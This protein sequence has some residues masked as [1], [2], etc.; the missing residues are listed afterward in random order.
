MK[1]IL[2]LLL[3]GIP[4]L[5]LAQPEQNCIDAIPVCQ[6]TYTQNTSY[7]GGGSITDIAPG[8]TCLGTGETNSVWYIF[9]VQN[10]GTFGFTLNTANDYDYAM[11]DI[12]GQ[13]C[14]IVG[15]TPPLRCNYSATYGLTGLDD[16][17]PQAGNISYNASQQPIMPGLNVVTG[18]TYVLLVNNFSGDTNG[19]DLNFDGTASIFDVTPPAYTIDIPCTDSENIVITINEQID[20]ATLSN[21]S[22]SLSGGGS[23]NSVVGTTC[24]GYSAEIILDWTAAAGGNYTLTS[25]GVADICGNVLTLTENISLPNP[26]TISTVPNPAELCDGAGGSVTLTASEAGGTWSPGGASTTAI[27]VSPSTTTTYTYS[28]GTGCV[29]TAMETVTVHPAPFASITPQNPIICGAGT[30]ALTAVAPPGSSFLW[31]GPDITPANEGNP[32]VLVGTGTYTVTITDVNGCQATDMT[33]VVTN[34]PPADPVCVNVYVSPAGGGTGDSPNSPTDIVSAISASLCSNTV[35]KMQVG[36]YNISAPLTISSNLTLEGGFLADW[37]KTSTDGTLATTTL[38]NRNIAGVYPWDGLTG[39]NEAPA[40]V[41]LTANGAT[42]FRLQDLTIQT[43]NAPASNSINPTGVSTYGVR[44][45]GCSNYNIV[46]CNIQAGNASAGQ[47]GAS[48]TDGADGGNGGPGGVGGS[49][50]VVLGFG[51]G[52]G[53]GGAT[54]GG[55]GFSPVGNTGGGGGNGG[56]AANS[57]SSG[58]NGGSGGGGIGP[59]GN[60]G[61]AGVGFSEFVGFG[62]DNP[63]APEEGGDGSPG[64]PGSPGAVGA[65]GA[66]SFTSGFFVPGTGTNG[67]D[68]THGGG[69][70]GGGGSG[71]QN[72]NF[73]C[74][75]D[76]GSG[77]GGGGGG[78]EAGTGGNGGGGG[79]A[80]IAI[81]LS[82]NGANGV[83]N[84]CSVNSGTLGSGGSGGM[85]GMGGNGGNGVNGGDN[86]ETGAG[87]TGGDG[88]DGGDGGNGGNG[89]AG[90]AQNVFLESGTALTTNDNSFNLIAQPI[91]TYDGGNCILTPTDFTGPTASAWD[92]DATSIPPTDNGTAVTTEYQD[93]GR[94]DI[95][96]NGNVYTGFVNIVLDDAINAHAFCSAP[97]IASISIYEAYQSCEGDAVDFQA[98]EL[99]L[100][101]DWEFS[102]IIGGPEPVP[103]TYLNQPTPDLTGIV[104]GNE[105]EYYIRHR[106]RTECCGWSAYDTIILVVQ[107]MPDIVMPPDAYL[108]D[109]QSTNLAVTVNNPADVDASTYQWSPTTGLDNPN[110]LSTNVSGLT[111]DQ[112]YT[113]SVFNAAGNCDTMAQVNVTVATL[114]FDLLLLNDATCGDNG[115]IQIPPAS[116]MGVGPYIYNWVPVLPAG[117]TNN[118]GV[119]LA[120][121]TY[122]V[123]IFDQTTGCENTKSIVVGTG[124]GLVAGINEYSLDCSAGGSATGTVVIGWNNGTS[125]YTVNWV[126]PS[127]SSQAGITVDSLEVT[128]LP[129]GNYTFTVT[130][131]AACTYDVNLTVNTPSSS[132]AANLIASND[133]STCGGT[134]GSIQVGGMNGQSPYVYSWSHDGTF[135]GA[136]ATNLADGS[137]TITVRDAIGCEES[138]VVNLAPAT[139][140]VTADSTNVTCIGANDGTATINAMPAGAYTYTWTPNVSS[141]NMATGLS[142][143]N[144]SVQVDGGTPGSTVNL[145]ES[146]FDGTGG[147]WSLNISDGVNG[148]GS[149]IWEIDDDEGGVVSGNCGT[150]GNGNNTLHVTCT[151]GI[152]CPGGNTGG[153]A[154]NAAVTSNVISESPNF[155]TAG[156]SNITLSFDYIGSGEAGDDF[157]TV[158]YSLDNGVT[159]LSVAG[160]SNP[161][162]PSMCCDFITNAPL[163]CTDFFAGQGL[164]TTLSYSLPDGTT[165][166]AFDWTNSNNNAGDDPSFAVDNIVVTG[167]TPGSSCSETVTFSII[168]GEDPQVSPLVNPQICDNVTSIDLDTVTVV[169]NSAM[170]PGTGVWYTGADNTGAVVSGVQSGLSNGDQFYYEFTTTLNSCIDGEVLTIDIISCCT[171]FDFINN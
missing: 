48:G 25:S 98:L 8:T 118:T 31:T 148:A 69:G 60:G 58:S 144:Y 167:D 49:C 67:T 90:V 115:T 110:A 64:T 7:S 106:V 153:A 86:C 131:N 38:I 84:D 1:K 83:I 78:A 66:S 35:I 102:T 137:Y 13:D 122:T 154:Y 143:G 5:L 80:S 41:A 52:G 34:P 170:Y 119:D 162:P 33:D 82:A 129:D 61:G 36:Q 91:I 135:N 105:G 159:W 165:N 51:C 146:D 54:G 128:G 28:V 104:F 145:Y 12:T 40:L 70:G 125:P 97:S 113:F 151:S 85:G 15:T 109:G 75:I 157:V 23:I 89:S 138:I 77:G 79:G 141:T 11:W 65:A 47:T 39:I 166:I 150:A 126:G 152:F 95:L 19:Y 14:S 20:C 21:A 94:K 6:Q 42:D 59:G 140:T 164:W 27:T 74:D 76:A 2:Y 107:P 26:P 114:E 142:P 71:G 132:L 121:G 93:V 139:L 160:P 43:A 100:E 50:T 30:A 55:G 120:P 87:G 56:N 10:A 16:G 9:T 81:F 163:V 103:N 92:F 130:D 133:P 169:V 17:N 112:T 72:C 46:R 171:D 45:I 136:N 155:S 149:N 161:V 134:D 3:L 156:H 37:S 116:L 22:F 117:S 32:T 29:L 96:Y 62:C 101:Y 53:V 124:A 123:T 168:D 73:A 4:S 127:S 44:L 111:S 88:G 158:L 18:N 68:G 99:G 108:C 63:G 24:G 57:G 147:S